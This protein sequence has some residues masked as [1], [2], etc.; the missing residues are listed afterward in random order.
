M[1]S[2]VPRHAREDAFGTNV[3][4]YRVVGD[5]GKP[6]AIHPFD[7]LRES[8]DPEVDEGSY[9]KYSAEGTLQMKMQAPDM[10]KVA[11]GSSFKSFKAAGEGTGGPRGNAA[12]AAFTFSDDKGKIQATSL[13]FVTD[14]TRRI[15]STYTNTQEVNAASTLY[16]D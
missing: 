4:C 3:S 8:R 15:F 2:P 14:V 12:S 16:K 6:H 5:D 1:P 10:S 7:Y 9:R 11:G 13:K